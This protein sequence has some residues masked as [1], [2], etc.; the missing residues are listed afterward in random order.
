MEKGDGP[1]KQ[2]DKFIQA[3]L[4]LIQRL[5][6]MSEARARYLYKPTAVDRVLE[7]TI[8]RLLPD[9]VTP[10]QITLFRFI[11]I[12]IIL[13]AL[14]TGYTPFGLVLF[15]I[16]ALSDAV[17]GALA[18]TKNHIT[19]WGILADPVADK[20]LIG[21]IS[22]SLV[23]S[24]VSVSLGLAIAVIEIFLILS[25]YYRYGGKVVP[26]KTVGKVKMILQC[27]GIGFLLLGIVTHV[28]LF[29][30]FAYWILLASVVFALL[31][32]FVYRS[33]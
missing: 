22:L 33:I 20:L 31:S 7:K 25:S 32:L 29:I 8:L 24:H 3:P 17:D 18:R 26:A 5:L 10:N 9:S 19:T 11:C 6:N 21:F 30:T 15:V 13:L 4:M 27:F 1:L 12:P 2:A 28:A 23:I 14:F 16:A